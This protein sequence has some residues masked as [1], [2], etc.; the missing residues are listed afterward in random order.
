M[1]YDRYNPFVVCAI[2]FTPIYQGSPTVQCPYCQT[3][4]QPEYQSRLCANCEISE[5]GAAVSG[6][7]C[8]A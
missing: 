7:K 2:S 6:L 5:I 4:Y 3:S 8:M 1:D